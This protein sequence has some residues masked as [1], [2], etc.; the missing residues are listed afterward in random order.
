[1]NVSNG[2]FADLY[3]TLTQ[4]LLSCLSTYGYKRTFSNYSEQP[5]RKFYSFKN[6]RTSLTPLTMCFL[7]EIK[8]PHLT[9]R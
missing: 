1:M 2:S 4:L 6:Y 3:R 5:M 9:G 8:S 7:S